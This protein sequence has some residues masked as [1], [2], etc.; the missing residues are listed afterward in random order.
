M[1]VRPMKYFLCGFLVGILAV[2]AFGFLIVYTKKINLFEK[3]KIKK[4]KKE[5]IKKSNNLLPPPL[6]DEIYG[7]YVKVFPNEIFNYYVKDF[8]ERCKDWKSEEREC[9]PFKKE[10]LKFKHYD[11]NDDGEY[12]LIIVVEH[13]LFCGSCGCEWDIWQLK[14]K[15]W[16]MISNDL[17]CGSNGAIIVLNKKRNGY[18]VIR[19]RQAEWKEL[20]D[21]YYYYDQKRG[22]YKSTNS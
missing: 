14:K 3:E 7:Y 10:N 21:E 18:R 1:D 16:Q 2:G 8:K 11:L 5:K 19:V 4:V 15:K 9:Y 22:M 20:K 12:E 17:A 6:P 13:M